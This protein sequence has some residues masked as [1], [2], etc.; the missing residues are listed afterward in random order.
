LAVDGGHLLRRE[1]KAKKMG[2]GDIFYGFALR[3]LLRR[4]AFS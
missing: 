4:E 2:C 1:L 3:S